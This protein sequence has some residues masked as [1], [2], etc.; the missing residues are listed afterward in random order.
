MEYQAW[1]Y[2]RWWAL[3]T[4]Y[5]NEG[6]PGSY[7]WQDGDDGSDVWF[8]LYL[9][10]CGPGFYDWNYAYSVTAEQAEQEELKSFESQLP[11]PQASA[12]DAIYAYQHFGSSHE[13]EQSS[14]EVFTQKVTKGRYTIELRYGRKTE[15]PSEE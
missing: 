15:L 7:I 3:Y 1:D 9:C 4:I 10:S 14:E 5:V 13:S 8:Y 2:S 12:D 11:Q 6:E